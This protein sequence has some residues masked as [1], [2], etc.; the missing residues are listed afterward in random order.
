[1]HAGG[2]TK[3]RRGGSW[4]DSPGSIRCGNRG[5]RSPD[6]ENNQVGFRLAME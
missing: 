2:E 5:K 6:R 1:L 3:V 4:A